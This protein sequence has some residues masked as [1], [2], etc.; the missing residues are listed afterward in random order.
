ME[1]KSESN[2]AKGEARSDNNIIFIVFNVQ[3]RRHQVVQREQGEER[4]TKVNE[5]RL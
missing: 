5:K 4:S 3:K 1:A 2:V